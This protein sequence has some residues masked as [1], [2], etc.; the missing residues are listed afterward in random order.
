[1]G[2][3]DSGPPSHLVL[4]PAPTSGPLPVLF[5]TPKRTV[6]SRP[7]LPTAPRHTLTAQLTGGPSTTQQ[8]DPRRDGQHPTTVHRPPARSASDRIRCGS[9]C[10]SVR[11]TLQHSGARTRGAPGPPGHVPDADSQATPPNAG[12]VGPEVG[13]GCHLSSYTRGGAAPGRPEGL[14]S[15]VP[16]RPA[17]A[18]AAGPLTLASPPSEPCP[19][20]IP[21]C[22]PQTSREMAVSLP[23][24]HSILAPTPG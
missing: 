2:P 23:K 4:R 10:L 24:K 5:L 17:G 1:M 20:P 9:L 3:R 22:Q 14:V 16:G 11:M 21:S 8:Q 18:G 6:L 7:F 12:S 19:G 15:D 13:P